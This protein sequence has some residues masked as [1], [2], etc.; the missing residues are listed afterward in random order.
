MDRCTEFYVNQSGGVG[1]T[2][3]VYRASFRTQRGH[4]IGS[5]F[6]ALF[7]FCKTLLHSEAKAVGEEVVRKGFNILTDLLHKIPDQQVGNVLKSRKPLL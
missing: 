4:S 7:L 1:N 5:F 6:R 2:G 3:S